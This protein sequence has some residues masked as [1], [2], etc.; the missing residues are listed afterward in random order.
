GD[1]AQI[2]AHRMRREVAELHVFHHALAQG[3]HGQVSRLHA[4]T[5]SGQNGDDRGVRV[6]LLTEESLWSRQLLKARRAPRW[7]GWERRK[8]LYP[9]AV[10]GF[11]QGTLSA[12]HRRCTYPQ[13]LLDR[14]AAGR[15][16]DEIAQPD[17]RCRYFGA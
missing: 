14:E 2:G 17:Y 7:R 9:N 13:A 12:P 8:A 10:S 15:A 11:V 5:P 16:D 3:R 6:T 1:A 4:W